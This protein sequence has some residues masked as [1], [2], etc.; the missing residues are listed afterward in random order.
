VGL[1]VLFFM[2]V[3]GCH[4]LATGYIVSPSVGAWMPAVV[5]LPLAAWMAQPMWE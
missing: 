5:L 4:A 1:T 3:L 2:I